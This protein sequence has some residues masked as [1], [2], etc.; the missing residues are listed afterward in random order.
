MPVPQRPG[1]T[2]K[3][4]RRGGCREIGITLETKREETSIGEWKDGGNITLE[5]WMQVV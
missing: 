5:S 2:S 4:N 3:W 1:F